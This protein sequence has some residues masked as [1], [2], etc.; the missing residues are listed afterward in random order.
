MGWRQRDGAVV[1]V[2]GGLCLRGLS[3][4]SSASAHRPRS[5]PQRLRHL[6]CSFSSSSSSSP[7]L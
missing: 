7:A 5:S 2:R 3:F 6:I 1:C 4:V